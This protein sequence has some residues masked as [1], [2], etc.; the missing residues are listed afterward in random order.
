MRKSTS[1]ASPAHCASPHT[2]CR[3]GAVPARCTAAMPAT[4]SSSQLLRP[5]APPRAVTHKWEHCADKTAWQLS[6]CFA[7]TKRGPAL[8]SRWRSACTGFNSAFRTILAQAQGHT[9]VAGI[10][11]DVPFA[12]CVRCGAYA[13]TH[14]RH[15]RSQCRGNPSTPS[16]ARAVRRVRLGLHPRGHRRVANLYSVGCHRRVAVPAHHAL[17]PYPARPRPAPRSSLHTSPARRPRLSIPSAPCSLRASTPLI[18]VHADALPLVETHAA[19]AAATRAAREQRTRRHI[20]EYEAS[21]ER[22]QRRRLVARPIQ[23]RN[24]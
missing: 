2:C 17:A 15:L 23:C 13:T 4:V 8:G 5:A 14:A 12:C 11:G 1:S 6:A 10:S 18:H 3:Y 16:S 20:H 24:D 21:D 22:S 7:V 19:E 9:L